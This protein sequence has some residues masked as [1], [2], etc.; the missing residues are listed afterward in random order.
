L[1]VGA[2]VVHLATASATESIS[3]PNNLLGFP[4]NCSGSVY[5][6][7]LSNYQTSPLI[8]NVFYKNGYFVLTNTSSNYYNIFTGTGSRGF[9]LNYQGSHAIYEHEHLISIR[10][11]EFNYSINPTAL[12]QSSL[13]FD[14]NQDGVFDFNDVDLIMRY[15]QKRKFFEEFVF[16]DN[17]IIL[18][19]DSLKDYS[20]WNNDILQLESEDVLLL[21]SDEAAYLASSSFNAFTKTAFDYIENNLVNTGLLD[22]DGDGKI[23]L[24]DGNIL[25]L[26]YLQRLTPDRLNLLINEDSTR[27]YVKEIKEYLNTYCRSDN[28]K[29]SPYFLEYQYSSSYDPTGSYLAPFITTI[30]LYDGN[31]LVAV[32]KLGRPVKN[33]IDWPLNIVVRFDT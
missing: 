5:V 2:P 31:E 28:A 22:I 19:Q 24:N 3:D 6:Y 30:G 7:N 21:E 9:D 12:V 26:Y 18:E 15:L 14:V 25:S 29:V 8:E 33:L 17:G 10:P 32:G 16:D 23:N 20:W 4:S 27:R 11:G 1:T 13:L